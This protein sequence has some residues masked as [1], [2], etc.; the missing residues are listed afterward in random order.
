M[1]KELTGYVGQAKDVFSLKRVSGVMLIQAELLQ[2][3]A[4]T[5]N[6]TR[7][8]DGEKTDCLNH[9]L[10]PWRKCSEKI[11]RIASF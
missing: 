2:D 5:W 11:A 7:L 10:Y 8:Q 9:L 4:A 3:F 6:V 1:S